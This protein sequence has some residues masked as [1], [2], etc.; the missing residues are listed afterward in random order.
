MTNEQKAKAIETLRANVKN[1]DDWGR[2]FAGSLLDYWDERGD[3]SDKQWSW[4][5]YLSGTGPKPGGGQRRQWNGRRST[6]QGPKAKGATHAET[7][8]REAE[9]KIADLTRQLEQAK[10]ESQQAKSDPRWEAMVNAFRHATASQ[11]K[12]VMKSMHP[13]RWGGAEW[14]TKVF[15]AANK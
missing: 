8:L 4:V 14:A 1:L 5:P 2:N 3:L 7:K 6:S 15:Q 10:M 12:Q 9:K 11:R 13:D